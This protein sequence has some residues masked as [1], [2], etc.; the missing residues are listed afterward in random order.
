MK[1]HRVAGR[2]GLRFSRDRE[3]AFH[4]EYFAKNLHSLRIGLLLGAVLF[5][6][7]GLVDHWISPETRPTVWI[8]RYGIACPAILATLLATYAPSFKRF[9]QPA[10]FIVIMTGGCSVIA[11]MAVV[12]S[13]VNY[14]HNAGLVLI[15]MYLFTFSNLRFVLAAAAAWLIV[16][17]Y[18]MTAVWIMH[19]P[20]SALVHDNYL[21]V[22]A[23]L[24]GMFSLYSRE[25][26]MRRDFLHIEMIRQL[27]EQRHAR[28]REKILRELHDVLGNITTNIRLMAEM[29]GSATDIGAVKKTLAAIS[30]LSREGLA[31]IKQFMQSLDDREMTWPCLAT[32]LRTSG[33]SLLEPHGIQFSMDAALDHDSFPPA[34]VLWLNLQRIY[35]EALTNA[36]KHSG[37]RCVDVSFDVGPRSCTLVVR[38]DGSGMQPGAPGGRGMSIMRRRAEEIGGEVTHHVENGTVMRAEFPLPV[39][40]DM[41]ET[42]EQA[43]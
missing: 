34:S 8:I 30:D 19:T 20:A 24:I 26:Y 29:G 15:L 5:A 16:A 14:V 7:F 37:G 21:Y 28:E 17:A 36:V 32:E 13:P 12:R 33:R 9:M 39:R 10:M 35:K 40:F 31:E 11:I 2:L 6:L 23:N 41:R 43:P 3:R 4:D 1:A 42:A 27:E 18:E 22:S 25:R 38:D